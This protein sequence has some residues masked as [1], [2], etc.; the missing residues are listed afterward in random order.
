MDWTAHMEHLQAIL[1]EF[2][3]IAA[4]NEEILIHYFRDGLCPSIWARVDNWRQDL[5]AWEKVVEKAID[6][7]ATA[8]LQPH[9][10]IREIDSKW[11]KKHRPLVKKDKDNTYQKHRDETFNKNKEKA[12]SHPLSSANQSQ[13]QASKKNKRHGSWQGHL[14]TGVNATKIAKTDKNRTKDLNHIECYTYKQKSR[15]ANKCSEKP[16]N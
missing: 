16:K 2:D 4:P 15:Y 3:P 14:A 9:S 1:K 6:A 7:K 12:K 13:A 8:G 10:M 11:P 5:D